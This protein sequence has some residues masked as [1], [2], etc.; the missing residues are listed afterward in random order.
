MN[1]NAIVE[2]SIS[3]HVTCYVINEPSIQTW[4]T[5]DSLNR[6]S[7]SCKIQ[8]NTDDKEKENGAIINNKRKAELYEQ[9]LIKK[10]KVQNKGK[11]NWCGYDKEL[12]ENKKFC[13]ACRSNGRECNWCHRPLPERFYGKQTDVCYSCITRRENYV[14]RGG[15]VKIDA[16]GSTVEI[17]T[18]H[19]S[20]GNLWDVLLFFCGKSRIN[21]GY[22]VQKTIIK[23]FLT[24]HVK[25]VKY[26]ENNEAVYAKLH[27]GVIPL[28]SVMHH[29]VKKK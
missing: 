12:L 21:C 19:H 7:N 16:L 25:F 29:S 28:F 3:I 26:N 14:Q 1:I 17:T 9:P 4:L 13:E 15:N 27:L 5:Q 18:I 11:C 8:R 10:R 2:G 22:V 24:L 6:H 23:W 20:P